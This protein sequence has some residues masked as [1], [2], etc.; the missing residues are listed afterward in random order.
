[1]KI[2]HVCLSAFYCEGYSYQENLLPRFHRRLGYEVDIIASLQSFDADGRPCLLAHTEDYVKDD[3]IHVVRLDYATP[4]GACRILRKYTG[5]WEELER[6]APDILFVHGVQSCE[7]ATLVRYVRS[8]PRVKMFMDNHADYSN[9]ATNWLSKYFLHRLIWRHYVRI[10]EPYVER[11]WGVLP[12]RVDFLKENYGL[13]RERCGLLVMG[14]DDGEVL[15]A[16]DPAVRDA[17]RERFGF[18]EK[19]YVVVTGGK[20]DTAKRQT[21]LLM[22]AVRSMDERVKLLVFGPVVPELKDEFEQKFD[23][24]KMAYVPWASASESYDY[25]AAAD[26]V[27]FPGRHSVYWEQAVAMGKPLIVKR[28]SGTEH[29]D[30]CGNVIFLDSDG[31]EPIF[32][33]LLTLINDCTDGGSYSKAADAAASRFLYSEIA[34]RSI[35]LE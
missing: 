13:P 2:C 5:L 27:C 25:F 30:I 18:G 6:S 32:R 28:W 7:N 16:S 20:I 10:V 33:A 12:A 17:V 11:F 26:A 35:E 31:V 1:M 19:D 29:I 22:D 4:K 3:G 9:S 21:F 24:K 8:H 15:R 34:K 23:P 14:A